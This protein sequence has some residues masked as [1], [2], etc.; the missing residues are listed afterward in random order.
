V[1]QGESGERLPGSL[2]LV[3]WQPGPLF[4][5]RPCS[6]LEQW[7]SSTVAPG[8]CPA[9]GSGGAVHAGRAQ[10]RQC[11]PRPPGLPACHSWPAPPGLPPPSL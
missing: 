8:G 1:L 9:A 3:P 11:V 6:R 5:A 4:D 10:H 2:T 7:S